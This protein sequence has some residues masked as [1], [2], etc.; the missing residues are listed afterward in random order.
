MKQNRYYPNQ[1]KGKRKKKGVLARIVHALLYLLSLLI[2]LG[3]WELL[4]VP[5]EEG[6]GILEQIIEE[7]VERVQDRKN[8]LETELEGLIPQDIEDL[9]DLQALQEL[10]PIGET[11]AQQETTAP[12]HPAET[13][14]AAD[15]LQARPTEESEDAADPQQV[16][17]PKETEESADPQQITPAEGTEETAQTEYTRYSELTA[18][19]QE[20]YNAMVNQLQTGSGETVVKGM[21]S[22]PDNDSVGRS[23]YAVYYDHPEF[24]WINGGYTWRSSTRGGKTDLTLENGTYDYWE[25]TTD[26]DGYRSR[27][28]AAA[29]EVAEQA[30]QYETQ[31]EQLK[32]VHDYLCRTVTYDDASFAE[33]N[34]STHTS[35]N[36]DYCHT[37]YGCL[38]NHLCVCDGY[39]KG[40]QLVLG[41]LG[42]PCYYVDGMGIHYDEEAGGQPESGAHAW[43]FVKVD[44]EYYYMDVTWDDP[45]AGEYPELTMYDYFCTT[46]D[47]ME[48]DHELDNSD[49]DFWYPKSTADENNYFVK[50]GLVLGQYDLEEI[51]KTIEKQMG[52][53]IVLHFS[54]PQ[55]RKAAEQKLMKDGDI[56]Q[57]INKRFRYY[58]KK[59]TLYIPAQEM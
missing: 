20:L 14:E 54:T 22:A 24:F 31:Y 41:K 29:E 49:G 36:W 2:T 38:V 45:D 32:F 13:E 34:S 5:K 37:A 19:E 6:N 47:G 51:R 15:P 59:N 30:W 10:L 52:Q 11:E 48:E 42:I 8:E 46:F 1:I 26:R 55:Q 12:V 44:G 50:N 4:S 57:I 35:P 58:T 9:E 18:A 43:N 3:S 16:R 28:E 40:L 56:N 7:I 27:L 33:L 21:S 23:V 25:Y 53:T 39:S 17:P